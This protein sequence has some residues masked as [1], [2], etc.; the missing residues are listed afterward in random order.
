MEEEEQEER[1]EGRESG[2]QEGHEREKMTTQ[3]E[4]VKMKKAN[5]MQKNTTRPETNSKDFG[6]FWT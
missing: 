2:V 5:S 4:C 1:R 6:S 3:E